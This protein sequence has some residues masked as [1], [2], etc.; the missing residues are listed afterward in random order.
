MIDPLTLL[1]FVPAAL[2]L[3]LSPGPEMMFCLGQGLRGG[4][5]AGVLA[6]AGLVPGPLIGVTLMALGLA[7]VT[8]AAPGAF[9]LVRWIGAG[10]LLWLAWRALRGDVA[11][12]EAARSG[13]GRTFGGSLLVGITSPKGAGFVFALLPQFIDPAGPVLAQF[14]ILGAILAASGFAVNATVGAF[15]GRFAPL[16]M[17][18]PGLGRLLRWLTAGVFGALAARL[19][20]GGRA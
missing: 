17:Q 16:L 11:A 7:S 14:L 20:I 1:A 2:V 19:L 18:S 13:A 12:P 9:P 10:Y 15:A 3:A 5:R 4:R 8:E 6:A